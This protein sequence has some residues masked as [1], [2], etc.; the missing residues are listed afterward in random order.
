[1]SNRKPFNGCSGYIASKKNPLTDIHNVIYIAAE[2]GIAVD[3]KYVT[4]S[5]AH[6]QMIG[7]TSIPNARVDMKDATQ[8]CTDCQSMAVTTATGF[9]DESTC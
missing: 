1:M 8:W 3:G 9:K 6:K 4:V 2:Q 7:S 5:E